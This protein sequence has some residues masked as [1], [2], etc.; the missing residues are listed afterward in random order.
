MQ[1]SFRRCF[2]VA[3]CLALSI[4]AAR[5]TSNHEYAKGEYAIIRG[6][7]APNKQLSLA[8]HGEGELG[9]ENFRVWLMA[10]PAH[11]RVI[12]L[13]D[14]SSEN[15]LDTDPDA[16][17]AF[18]SNDSEHVGVAF[19]SSR[20]EVKL[21][22]YRIENRRAH[23]IAGPNLFKEVT[24]REVADGDGLRTHNAIVEWHGGNRFLFREALSF[25]VSDDHLAKLLGAY[26]SV[27]EKMDGGKLYIEFFANA[28][29]ELLPGDRVRVIDLKPGKHGDADNW[30]QP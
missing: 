6:G 3:A 22:L 20:H 14:I 15:N 19:R 27:T 5:A 21:N 17:H 8:S 2:A 1:I 26:G 10:E 7:L 16:Y 4:M 9:D 18:W 24:S 23:L 30:W 25:V 11:H 29:C 12:K 28:E 13:D